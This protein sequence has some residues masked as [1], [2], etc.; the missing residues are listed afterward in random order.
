MKKFIS[1]SGGV[2]ST[3]MALLYGKGAKAIFCDTGAEHELMYQRLDY[4]ENMLKI[5]HDNDFEII[6]IKPDVKIKGEQI[7][8]LLDAVIVQ[9]FMP[10]QMARYC[11]RQFKI[12]PID[13]FLKA[14]GECELMIGLNADEI[15]EGNYGLNENVKYYYPLQDDGYNRKDCEELLNQYGL[16]P[17]FPA[18]MLRGGCKMCFFKTEKEYKAMYYMNPDEFESVNIFEKKYQDKRSKFYTILSNGK[19]MEQ[20]KAE[21][22]NELFTNELKEIY[23]AYN[24]NGKS[25]GAFCNR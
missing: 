22:Q 15:R 21:C 24:K 7:N 5:I 13:N 17:N 1:F 6:R 14:I 9:K 4:V 8:S 10:S 12:E 11:T 16:H 19:S 20:I 25:C 3:T 2:E 23:E 18:Y